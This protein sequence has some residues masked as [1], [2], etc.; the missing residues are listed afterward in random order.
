MI[1]K[2]SAIIFTNKELLWIIIGF[3]FKEYFKKWWVSAGAEG[4]T[5]WYK[6]KNGKIVSISSS[7]YKEII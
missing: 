1:I 2:M 7:S 3:C 5:N 4:A 6:V